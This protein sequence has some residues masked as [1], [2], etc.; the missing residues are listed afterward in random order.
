VGDRGHLGSSVHTIAFHMKSI[1]A[2][3]QVHSRSAA[4]AKALRGRLVR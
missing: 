2:K 3:L 1:Y 4:V